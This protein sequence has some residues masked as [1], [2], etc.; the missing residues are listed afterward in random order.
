MSV[1]EYVSNIFKTFIIKK[2]ERDEWF[3][4]LEP[5]TRS[6]V[7]SC[8]IDEERLI[9]E[10]YES[11]EREE[12]DPLLIPISEE[13]RQEILAKEEYSELSDFSKKWAFRFRTTRD[14]D[15]KE[16]IRK[17]RMERYVEKYLLRQ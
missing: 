11:K 5:I 7:G 14:V 2:K 9:A 6:L 15:W 12:K 1:T 10:Y 4:S 8:Q 16:E 17:A 3:N 13:E